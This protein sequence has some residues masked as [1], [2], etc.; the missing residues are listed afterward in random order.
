MDSSQPR[1][2]SAGLLVMAGGTVRS[3]KVCSDH[4][5]AADGRGR[6]ARGRHQMEVTR[7]VSGLRRRIA[8]I[9]ERQG[10]PVETAWAEAD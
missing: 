8:A 7:T 3:E 9:V 5:L 6:G 10:A 2:A 4:T 1:P